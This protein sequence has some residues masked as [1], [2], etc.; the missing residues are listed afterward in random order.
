MGVRPGDRV[1]MF[2]DNSRRWIAAD[3]ALQ[4]VRAVSVPRGTDTPPEEMGEIFR[5]AEVGLVLAH[6]AARADALA[7]IRASVPSMGEV[8]SLEPARASGRTLDDLEREGAS[9]PEFG[10]WAG[11][12]RAEDVATIIYTSGTTGRPKGVVL[13][14]ANF[15][16]QV[17]VLP[18]LFHMLPSEVFLSILPPWHIFERTVEYAALV[19]G[20]CIAYTSRRHLRDDMARFRP[21]FMASVPRLWEMVY[22]GVRKR[23]DDGSP[24][25]RSVFRGAFALASLR[26][27]GWDRARGHVLRVERPRGLGILREGALRAAGVAAAALAFPLDRLAHRVVFRP[28]RAATGGRMRGAISGGG[29]MPAHIDRFFRTIGVPIL[30]GYGLTETSPVV[31]V[32]REGRN[33]L[34]TIGTAV[35]DVEIEIRDP[36]TRRPLPPGRPGLVFTRGPHVMRGYHHDDEL[37]RRAIDADRWFDTGDLGYLTEYGDLCFVGR[38]KE[39]IVLSGGE[40]VEPQRVEDALL[41][42]PLIQQAVVVGQDHKTLAALLLPEPEAVARALG[43]DPR[44]TPDDL[45]ARPDV[46]ALLHREAIRRTT[47]LKPFE[48]VARVALLHEALDVEGGCLT[49]TMKL[50]RHVV[51]RRYAEMIE[52]VLD[53]S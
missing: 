3:L 13:S 5:H 45:A 34:G 47:N 8:V 39:T 32:R 38:A 7:S 6:D 18:P 2:A 22:D 9:G 37:T 19:A 44:R 52:Q 33:V 11:A 17:R 31:A 26:A 30:V 48:R 1:G 16:H 46:L 51:A 50:R 40:N 12:V 23:L 14:Q 10:A 41:V 21:T 35:E 43:L 42:S 28:V 27:W 4:L 24:L 29:L 20:A 49:Q 36:E 15:A 53:G 25:R